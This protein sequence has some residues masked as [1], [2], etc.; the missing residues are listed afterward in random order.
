MLIK[1]QTSP[2]DR[3]ETAKRIR[4]GRIIIANF[5][6]IKISISSKLEYT[7]HTLPRTVPIVV[8]LVELPMKLFVRVQL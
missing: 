1:R 8:I 2:R 6:T 3:Q 4:K 7:D 5:T